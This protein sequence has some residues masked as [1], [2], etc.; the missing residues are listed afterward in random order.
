MS[1]ETPARA[2]ECENRGMLVPMNACPFGLRQR[3]F[4]TTP[5]VA[6]YYPATSHERAVE[7]LLA[8]LADGE[9]ILLLAGAPG[10][11]E[12][13]VC[14][15]ILDLLGEEVANVCITHTHLRNRAELLQAILF[16]LDMPHAGKSEQEL[17]LTLIDYLLQRFRAGKQTVLVIDEAQHLGIDLLE[18]LR[19]LSNL[20]G[21]GGKAVQV[22]LAGQPDLL[23]VLAAPALASL[24]QRLAVRVFLEPLGIDEAA[25]YLLHHLRSAGGQAEE[26]L[27]GV[28]VVLLARCTHGLPR[29]LNQAGRQALYLAEQVGAAEMDAEAVLEA[30]TLLGL[31]G[32]V[33]A[34]ADGDPDVLLVE[35]S[36][37]A[38][39]TNEVEEATNEED[40]A[41][42]L[43]VAPG[44]SA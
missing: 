4:P 24:R 5:D 27:Y 21:Q 25:D 31:P 39:K 10:T 3:P 26:I 15:R 20:E 16:D 34:E 13:L 30:L 19:M 37:S 33:P 22:L 12:T 29:L 1:V 42:R 36:S 40:D 8:G 43:F 38:S 23:D 6:C 35:P 32:E 11:G 41:H 14:H 7:R 18:E 28:A 9:G 17:R 44:R 2:A